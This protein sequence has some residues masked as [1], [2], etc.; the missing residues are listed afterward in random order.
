MRGDGNFGKQKRNTYAQM[1]AESWSIPFQIAYGFSDNFQ[2]GFQVSYDNV[3]N[4]IIQIFPGDTEL[5]FSELTLGLFG[6]YYPKCPPLNP[7][8]IYTFLEGN[9]EYW[10]VKE[11]ISGVPSNKRNGERIYSIGGLGLSLNLGEN[12]NLDA[13]LGL[14]LFESAPIEEAVGFGPDIITRGM[15]QFKL[16]DKS[17]K[18]FD[19]K[20]DYFRKGLF[21]IGGLIEN[22]FRLNETE[23]SGFLFSPNFSIFLPSR[24]EIGAEASLKNVTNNLSLFEQ[25]NYLTTYIRFYLKL[26]EQLNLVIAPKLTLSEEYNY[27]PFEFSMMAFAT[28]NLLLESGIVIYADADALAFNEFSEVFQVGFKANAT[29]FFNNNIG[30]KVALQTATPIGSSGKQTNYQ[31]GIVMRFMGK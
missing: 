21:S 6:K 5:Q 11:V 28:R 31:T 25:N 30:W 22:S 17:N 7:F 2:G 10:K 27:L 12:V 23:G 8:R 24:I 1:T 14:L 18:D 29:W 20:T 13:S 26:N 15:I 16:G 3:Q 9:L 19:L 4:K